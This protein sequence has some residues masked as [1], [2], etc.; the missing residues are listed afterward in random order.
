MIS[1]ISAFRN[2]FFESRFFK[3]APKP[4]QWVIGSL[5]NNLGY[6]L[7]SLL[8]AILLW[9]YVINTNT[10]ITRGKTVY[11]L[12]GTVSGQ[13]A[14]SVN[15]LAMTEN[16][17]NL[18]SGIAVTVEAPQA[19]YSRVSADNIQVTLDL[20]NIRNVGTQEVPLRATCSYGSVRSISP[21]TVTLAFEK[22]DSRN[23]AVNCV[24]QGEDDGYWYSVSR[25]N[26]SIL[27]ISGPASVVQSIASARVVVDANGLTGSTVTAL[28]Y[29]RLDGEGNEI[30]QDLLSCSTSSISVNLDVYPCRD[31]PVSTDVSS[32]ITGT[33]AEGYE[34]QS[35]AIQ[36][37]TIQVAAE[38][39]LLSGLTEIVIEPVSIEGAA[40]SFSAKSTVTQLSDFKNVS[41]EQV[42]VNVII[43]EETIEQYVDENIKVVFMGKG[44]GLTVGYDNDFGVVVS[45][46]R[47]A[48]EAL[49]SE[50]LTLNVDLSGLEAGYYLL[51]PH[52]ED[53]LPENCNILSD[54]IAVTL[55]DADGEEAI[56][57][58]PQGQD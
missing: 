30:R 56:I 35:V 50:G 44:E 57:S 13:S 20:S 1:R 33:P 49:V 26:P 58:L 2:R 47:S 12:T 25:S 51:A 34:L 16:P 31:I 21:Q 42:Y 38:P 6:K 23:V 14:L 37:E 7:L 52:A 9:N 53:T 10:S 19:V 29:V 48:V 11:N 27:T 8:L 41:S 5:S 39:E 15:K 22:L 46:P 45:G 55:T 18:L 40:Q 4:L 54:A 28:P 3:K 43:A 17:E 36:P 32:I 24:I